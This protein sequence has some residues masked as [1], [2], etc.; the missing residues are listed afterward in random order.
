MDYYFRKVSGNHDPGEEEEQRVESGVVPAA[1]QG[2]PV[3]HG[4]AGCAR[5]RSRLVS[6]RSIQSLRQVQAVQ[7]REHGGGRA[8][9]V[10]RSLV[11]MGRSA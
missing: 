8:E 11:H 9:F 4:T 1:V 2:R 7:D 5:C 6:A 10:A 3:D